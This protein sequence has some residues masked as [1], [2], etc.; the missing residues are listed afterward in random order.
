ME[1]QLSVTHSN[2][3]EGCLTNCKSPQTWKNRE[4]I[5]E[6][7]FHRVKLC[8]KHIQGCTI[9]RLWCRSLQHH[10]KVTRFHFWHIMGPKIAIPEIA[11]DTRHLYSVRSVTQGMKYPQRCFWQRIMI[12]IFCRG[13]RLSDLYFPANSAGMILI[14][15]KCHIN[16]YVCSSCFLYIIQCLAKHYPC[17]CKNSTIIAVLK[18]EAHGL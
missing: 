1:Q 2:A 11:L 13:Q 14:I 17:R 4:N 12:F 6:Q 5:Y 16:I 3:K 9:I 10:Y 15:Y 7:L 18:H 8:L